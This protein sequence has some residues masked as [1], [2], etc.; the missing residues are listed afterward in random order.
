MERDRLGQ[1]L[2]DV[3]DAQHPPLDAA[4][5][6]RM[7]PRFAQNGRVEALTAEMVDRVFAGHGSLAAARAVAMCLRKSIRV[8]GWI[9][10][11]KT[12]VLDVASAA[13]LSEA[14]TRTAIAALNLLS[15]APDLV[16]IKTLESVL[17]TCVGAE[18][19][20]VG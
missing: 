20:L 6:A 17:F 3:A 2:R 15:A 16:Q 9:M 8:R 13:G 18:L 12:R 11:P 7:Y 19:I 5:I 4:G 10:K 14:A 1:K